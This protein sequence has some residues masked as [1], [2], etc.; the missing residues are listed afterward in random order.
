[1]NREVS[2]L[3]QN[4]NLVKW[5]YK[6]DSLK[7]SLELKKSDLLVQLHTQRNFAFTFPIIDQSNNLKALILP[8]WQ[9]IYVPLE[10]SKWRSILSYKKFNTLEGLTMPFWGIDYEEYIITYIVTNRFNN[11]LSFQNNDNNALQTRF[12][13]K[14]TQ[15]R[16]VKEH[17]FIIRLSERYSPVEPAREFRNYLINTG[18][19]VSMKKK[20]NPFLKLKDC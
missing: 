17:S 15:N 14:F 2:N 10:N 13:H 3:I 11:T 19:F 20:Q 9:G 7:V 4:G 1:V 8:H 18:Q 5:E 6:K 16:D 12:T